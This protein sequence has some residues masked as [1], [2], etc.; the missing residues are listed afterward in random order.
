MP[1]ILAQLDQI[2]RNAIHDAFGMECDALVGEGQAL[3]GVSQNE[4]FGDY[5][6]N[7]AM[8]LVKTLGEKTGGKLSPRAIAEQIKSKL[9]LGSMASDVTIAGPGFINVRLS[10][11]WLAQQL[12]AIASDHRLGIP[13]AA[14]PQNIVVDYSGPNIAKEMHVGNLRSTNIGDAMS[15]VLEFQQHRV[16]RQNHIGDW[17]TQ[18]GRVVLAI[19]YHVMAEHLHETDA[20]LRLTVQMGQATD[21]QAKSVVV[22]SLAELHRRMFQADRDGTHIFEQGLKKFHLQLSML[23]TLYQFVSATTEHPAAKDEVIDQEGNSLADLPR[24]ITTFIQNPK[25]SKNRQEELAWIKAREVTLKTCEEIYSQLGVK[26]RPEDV[27]GESAYQ[28]DLPVIV[29]ELKSASI[30]VESEGAIVVEVPGYESPLMIQK[31]DGGYLYG[32]T[33]LAAIRYRILTLGARRIIY[34]HDS[35]Q[36]EHFKKVFWTARKIGW[37]KDVSLEYAPFGT[38]LGQDGKP[39]KTRSG[40][41]VKLKGLLDE[42]E[43]RAMA[44]V[45]E[46]QPDLPDAQRR[47]IAHAVGIGAVK[48]ADLSKDRVSDYVFSFDQMLALDGNTA[49]YLQYAHARI[50]S[51]F[52]KAGEAK[53]GQ[54]SLQSP[55]ELALAKHILRLGEVIDLVARE[56]KPHHL[57]AYVYELA[58][59]FSGF[60]ENCPVIQ[61]EPAI[62]A[63]RL[64]LCDLTA[65]TFELGLD[66]LGIEHPDQM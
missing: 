14:E 66:L 56:L 41:T 25:I 3:V 18:F 60:F 64:A 4:K 61:S 48:Y 44:V 52:R 2:F 13:G 27:R 30:A 31:S 38:I 50:R 17:G 45:T 39:F 65:R 8:G 5:Q 1:T 7:A 40:T 32:T 10:P 59:R 15:R 19:W 24:L 35:R 54:I 51:I 29:A 53:M 62:R 6:S 9:N 42:A 46:K 26:L 34:T 58:T 23:E 33:D 16:I 20:L 43:E 57:C 12:N 21:A 55:F 47:A 28:D 37:G 49:P 11:D 22:H 36:Q 63:S